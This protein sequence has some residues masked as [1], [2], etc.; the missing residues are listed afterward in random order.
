MCVHHMVHTTWHGAH[1]VTWCTPGVYHVTWCTPRD[2][3]HTTWHGAHQGCIRIIVPNRS[4][5]VPERPEFRTLGNGNHGDIY[6]SKMAAPVGH[7]GMIGLFQIIEV[8]MEEEDSDSDEECDC[9]EILIG[10]GAMGLRWRRMRV[11]NF[12]GQVDMMAQR[13][14]QSH[15]RLSKNTF[16]YICDRLT[17]ALLPLGPGGL[18]VVA[19][20]K[21]LL[22]FLAYIC[23]QDSIRE[24]A[25]LFGISESTV[26][27]IV[28]KIAKEITKQKSKFIR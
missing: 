11:E 12:D 23:N 9:V 2:M 17:I 18:D 15:F 26:H 19:P 20:S 25:V 3:V 6:A 7:A 1:H 28:T 27:K 16:N 4:R 14:F 22:V 5:T 10:T 21:Q 13:E 8:A 24:V